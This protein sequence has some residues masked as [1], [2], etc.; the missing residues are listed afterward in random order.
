MSCVKLYCVNDILLPFLTYANL[1]VAYCVS[2]LAIHNTFTAQQ[3]AS[4]ISYAANTKS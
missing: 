1:H 2:V 3:Y 4:H